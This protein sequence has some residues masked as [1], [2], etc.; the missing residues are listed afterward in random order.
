[1]INLF[2][3]PTYTGSLAAVLAHTFARQH[4]GAVSV[5]RCTQSALNEGLDLLSIAIGLAKEQGL[6]R[7]K[8]R[9]VWIYGMK[10]RFTE[11]SKMLK[12][13]H[14]R[15]VDSIAPLLFDPARPVIDEGAGG[16][17]IFEFFVNAPWMETP[18]CHAVLAMYNAR[19]SDEDFETQ[20]AHFLMDG[21][22]AK[23]RNATELAVQLSILGYPARAQKRSTHNP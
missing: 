8:E 9:H 23:A 13:F 22:K 11:E 20:V 16:E 5:W 1:M 3:P 12:S 7:V 17:R 14:L 2:T 21:W 10:P 18:L 6:D 4:G 19:A 15:A